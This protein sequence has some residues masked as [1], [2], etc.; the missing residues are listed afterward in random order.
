MSKH[1][2]RSV[3]VVLTAGV[4]GLAAWALVPDTPAQ[5]QGPDPATQLVVKR[6]AV[7]FFNVGGPRRQP[8]AVV[9][10]VDGYGQPVNDALVVGDWSGCFKETGDSALTQTYCDLQDDGTEICVDGRAELYSKKTHSCWGKGKECNFT[11]TVTGVSKEG[12]TYVP[13]AGMTTGSI[14]CR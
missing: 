3:A 1:W 13:V 10:I 12:M 11:F 14:P 5:A 2:K 7:N 6:I 8:F 9:E 4:I